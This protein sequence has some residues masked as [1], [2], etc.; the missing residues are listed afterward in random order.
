MWRRRGI[1]RRCGRRGFWI[2]WKRGCGTAVFRNGVLGRSGRRLR[3]RGFCWCYRNGQRVVGTL[4]QRWGFSSFA[5]RRPGL[6]LSQKFI[7]IYLKRF[8]KSHRWLASFSCLGK[9]HDIVGSWEAFHIRIYVIVGKTYLADGE[10]AT[11]NNPDRFSLACS[12]VRPALTAFARR[13][14]P[15]Y[16]VTRCLLLFRLRLDYRWDSQKPEHFALAHCS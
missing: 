13:Q 3:C 10:V 16:R 12:A 15:R 9:R 5:W 2:G 14:L 11:H 7:L 8:H 6:C 4:H 1:R